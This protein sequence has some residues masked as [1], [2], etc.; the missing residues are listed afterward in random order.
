MASKSDK[1]FAKATTKLGPATAIAAL[2]FTAVPLA[3]AVADVQISPARAQAIQQCNRFAARY[4]L[5]EQATPH[6]VASIAAATPS[7]TSV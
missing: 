3:G 1:S 7:L 2:W 6:L 4:Y 5:T